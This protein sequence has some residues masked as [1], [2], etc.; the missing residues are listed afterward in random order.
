MKHIPIDEFR[1][2]GYLQEVNRQFFHPLGLGLEITISADGTSHISGV[3]DCR[4]APEGLVFDE[5]E[6]EKTERVRQEQ[7]RRAD[8]RF[9]RLGFVIQPPQSIGG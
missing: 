7:K 3:W 9:E 1:E 6:A 5:I 8:I 2:F 4:D